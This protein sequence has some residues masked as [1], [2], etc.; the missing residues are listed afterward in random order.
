MHG[1]TS[2]VGSTFGKL[3]LTALAVALLVVARSGVDA[4]APETNGPAVPFEVALRVGPHSFSADDLELRRRIIQF[5]YPTAD[6]AQVGAAVQFIE[7]YLI[8]ELL[9]R[10]GHPITDEQLDAEIARIN[11][12]TRDPDGLRRLKAICGGERTRAYGRIAILPEF[13]NRRFFF[14]IYPNGE[15]LH[16]TQLESARR[17]LRRL[18]EQP[19][20]LVSGEHQSLLFSVKCGFQLTPGPSTPDPRW[21]RYERE[22]FGPTRVG[23]WV[24]HVVTF[25]D[26]F[27]LLRWTGWEDEQKGIR[28][29]ERLWFPKRDAHT[30]FHQEASNIPLWIAERALRD[31]LALKKSW[32]RRLSWEDL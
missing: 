24:N 20:A 28:R 15:N 16:R 17:T 2:T 22:L 31:A 9:R 27:E 12:D 10:M 4:S 23:Q 7:G 26:G 5:K 18:L 25:P 29:I 32:M 1:K 11:R 3:L 14:D 21:E 30:Y 6:S 13:A 8:V 19:E